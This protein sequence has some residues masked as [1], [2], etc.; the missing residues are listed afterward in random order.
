MWMEAKETVLG[1][2]RLEEPVR[3]LEHGPP[4]GCTG[5]SS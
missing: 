1:N 2:I 5:G 3:D 4:R